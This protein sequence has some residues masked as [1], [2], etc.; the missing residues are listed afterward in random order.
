MKL[1][2][3]VALGVLMGGLALDGVHGIQ[4]LLM[5]TEQVAVTPA[6]PTNEPVAHIQ[7]NSIRGYPSFPH[8]TGPSAADEAMADAAERAAGYQPDALRP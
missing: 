6:E 2:M 3:E 1:A 4:T 5:H 8:Q 7:Q